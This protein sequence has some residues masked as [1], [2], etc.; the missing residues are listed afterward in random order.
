MTPND[1]D[2]KQTGLKSESVIRVS[3]LAVVSKSILLG[4]VGEISP[5]RLEK[6]TKNLST[7]IFAD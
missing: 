4:K 7:W 1:P 5:D 3:R 6:V 2:F